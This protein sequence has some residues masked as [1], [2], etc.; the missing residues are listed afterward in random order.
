MGAS[1]KLFPFWWLKK[2]PCPE[3]EQI[4]NGDFE[5]GTTGWVFTSTASYISTDYSHS[6]THSVFTYGDGTGFYQLIDNLPVH[7]VKSLTFWTIAPYGMPATI[8]IVVKYSDGTESS[9][10]IDSVPEW[11][12]QDVTDMLETGKTIVEIRFWSLDNNPTFIDDVSLI[13]GG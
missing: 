13:S 5:D 11:T 2:P 8:V 1:A 3:G 12:Q 9:R 6:P 10:G 4:I 7:C